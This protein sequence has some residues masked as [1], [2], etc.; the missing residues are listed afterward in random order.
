MK[1][2]KLCCETAINP[3]IPYVMYKDTPYEHLMI[4][5]R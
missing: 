4:P 2:Q 1:C 5:I 3:A